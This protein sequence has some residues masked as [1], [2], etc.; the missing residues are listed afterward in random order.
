MACPREFER[1]EVLPKRAEES[2]NH[3]KDIPDTEFAKL[4]GQGNQDGQAE[5][6]RDQGRRRA[7]VHSSS[8]SG[9]RTG[10]GRLRHKF[11]LLRWLTAT[12]DSW[13]PLL[14]FGVSAGTL[15]KPTMRLH[16]RCSSHW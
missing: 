1:H 16:R 3:L 15:P 8:T 9:Y 13:R 14:H 6:E 11:C 10:G 4:F 7:R 5:V 2:E 12:P